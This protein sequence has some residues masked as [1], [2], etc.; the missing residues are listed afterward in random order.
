MIIFEYNCTDSDSKVFIRL[1][2]SKY[3]SQVDVTFIP[4]LLGLDIVKV[5]SLTFYFIFVA[6]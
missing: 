4:L 1:R 6:D 3:K 2:F 5:I